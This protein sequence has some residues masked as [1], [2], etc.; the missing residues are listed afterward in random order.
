MNLMTWSDTIIIINY[1][2]TP[3]LN[4]SFSLEQVFSGVQN[5]SD[6]SQKSCTQYNLDSP[7]YSQPFQYSFQTFGDKEQQLQLL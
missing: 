7:S 3:A 5:S 2:F 1:F 6:R 4:G